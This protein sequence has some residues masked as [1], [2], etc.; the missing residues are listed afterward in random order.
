MLRAPTYARELDELRATSRAP[1]DERRDL[2]LDLERFCLFVGAGRSGHSLVGS[3][4][5]AH[6]EVIIAHQ[7]HVLHLVRG[8]FD[9]WQ[10]FHLLLSNSEHYAR[11]G[12]EET[13]YVYTV[14]GQWHGRFCRLRVIGDKSGPA[15]EAQLSRQPRLLE[16]LA[17]RV[18]LPI[19]IV[20][21]VRNPYDNVS[22]MA[23]RLDLALPEAIDRYFR[24]C[25]TVARLEESPVPEALVH[26]RHED[27]LADPAAQL[28]RLCRS[29]GVEPFSDYLEDA[30]KIVRMKPHRSRHDAPWSPELVELVAERSA[31]FPFLAGYSFAG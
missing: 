8:G 20:H 14:P 10:M 6:P 9:R 23:K 15:S 7:L 28:E 19:V 22:T 13:Q 21:C 1:S 24:R 5:D 12:R 17:E 2:F 30:A 27:L 11:E 25:E 4:L 18:E 3:L 29:L 31:R 26:V 16:W